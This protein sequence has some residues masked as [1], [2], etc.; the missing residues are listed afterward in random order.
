MRT[1]TQTFAAA[2]TWKLHVPGNYF[3]IL[4]C[5]LAVNVRFYNHGKQ[6]DLGECNALLAGLEVLPQK[7]I[8]GEP[9]FTSVEI[10][11]GGADTVQIG[12]GDGSAR[13]NRSQ[14]NVTVTNVNG[15][16]TDSQ[17]SLTNVA[18]T[19]VAA[20]AARRYVLVQNNDAAAVMRVS[21]D[22]TP[23][24]ATKGKRVQPGQLLE[25]QGFVATTAISVIM[26]TA[27]AAANNVDVTVG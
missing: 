25:L 22:G 18:Q 10:D 27:T 17:L 13:Y 14:G 16:F 3:T 24:T 5:A 6:L 4:A 21:L 12:I 19:A 15:A 26:E 7:G 11:I 1:F 8:N 9:A 20:N 2:S 23:A